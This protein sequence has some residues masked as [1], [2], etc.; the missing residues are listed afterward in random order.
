[1]P[2][3]AK[4]T[5]RS[6]RQFH[7]MPETMKKRATQRKAFIGETTRAKPIELDK[8]DRCY[9]CGLW[10]DHRSPDCE[11]LLRGV[12]RKGAR[13]LTGSAVRF[14]SS[15]AVRKPLLTCEFWKPS[16][17][18]H[19]SA[20]GHVGLA[21][22]LENMACS[23]ARGVVHDG[24]VRIFEDDGDFYEI[25]LGQVKELACRVAKIGVSTRGT[26][27]KFET[28]SNALVVTVY[29]AL[30]DGTVT[31]TLQRIEFVLENKDKA[32]LILEDDDELEVVEVPAKAKPELIEL[33]DDDDEI[34]VLATPVRKMPEV[35]ELDGSHD[36]GDDE[37]EVVEIEKRKPES[38]E[39]DDD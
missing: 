20:D 1:M 27:P 39:L 37:I 38:V 15:K 12:P 5:P 30:D 18:N 23:R 14:H 33:G 2:K 25:G 28:Q 17:C 36:D 11:Y 34:E 32:D 3:L 24:A 22:P 26:A 13:K 21:C 29:T 35:V 19:C 4:G 8:H 10:R 16:F 6:L 9:H 31:Y 7:A